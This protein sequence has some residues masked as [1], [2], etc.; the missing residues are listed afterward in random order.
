MIISILIGLTMIT[1]ILLFLYTIYGKEKQGS[2]AGGKFLY[3]LSR[4][5]SFCI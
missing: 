1:L 4:L 3:L 2:P 5:L